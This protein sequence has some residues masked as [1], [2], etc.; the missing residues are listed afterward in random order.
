MLIFLFSRDKYAYWNRM[1]Y[2]IT[3]IIDII[4]FKLNIV[5]LFVKYFSLEWY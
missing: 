2:V 3:E 5:L 1:F 4:R